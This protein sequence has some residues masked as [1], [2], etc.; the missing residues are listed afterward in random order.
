MPPLVL[1]MRPELSEIDAIVMALKDA[2][3]AWLP[4]DRLTGLEIAAAEALSNAVRHGTADTPRDPVA[5]TLSHLPDRVLVEIVDAG[6]PPP[7]DLFDDVPDPE[8][9]DPMAES[10]RG[11]SLIRHC[12]DD[13]TF[14]HQA[15]RN[16]LKMAFMTGGER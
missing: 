15:G 1:Q 11:L 8:G 2:A 4:D 10:G 5:V 14:E 16:R 3:R 7:D 12:V 9:I 6:D 13:L